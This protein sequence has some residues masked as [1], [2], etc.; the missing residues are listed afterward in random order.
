MIIQRCVRHLS[1]MRLRVISVP[2]AFHTQL[3]LLLITVVAWTASD[4]QSDDGSIDTDVK[5]LGLRLD[6]IDEEIDKLYEQLDNIGPPIDRFKLYTT[7]VRVRNLT[8]N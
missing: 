4:P 8:G 7:M 1:T 6:N 5:E 2:R 3:L